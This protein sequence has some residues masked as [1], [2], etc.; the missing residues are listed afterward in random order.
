MRDDTSTDAPQQCG[1]FFILHRISLRLIS[2][3]E[4]GL[5]LPPKPIF[6][7]VEARG[8]EPPPPT[9]PIRTGSISTR[10][11]GICR[12]SPHCRHKSVPNSISVLNQYGV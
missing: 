12:E 2:D 11:S 10:L 3:E 4:K 9:T 1:A 5:S 8:F 6:L 7:L